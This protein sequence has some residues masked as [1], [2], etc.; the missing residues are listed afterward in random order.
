[1]SGE[2]PP[3][4]TDSE[5][6]QDTWSACCPNPRNVFLVFFFFALI[7]LGLFVFFRFFLDMKG[8][9]RERP[10]RQIHEMPAAPKTE[11]ENATAKRRISKP[12]AVAR[13]YKK[14][15]RDV[16]DVRIG[17]MQKQVTLFTAK[18]T[19]L[20]SRLTNYVSESQLRDDEK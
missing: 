9:A 4:A 15:E 6:C 19:L 17:T 8:A 20:Q 14:L 18:I 12:R 16:L 10:T 7:L 11:T 13:P 3:E 1:M 5:Q 2:I